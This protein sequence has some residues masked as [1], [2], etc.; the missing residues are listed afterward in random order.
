MC[1]WGELRQPHAFSQGRETAQDNDGTLI[2]ISET[3]L[4][5]YLLT[6]EARFLMAALNTRR[7]A[8]PDTK[9]TA[10][11]DTQSTIAC[12]DPFS[13]PDVMEPER[14]AEIVAE[15]SVECL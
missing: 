15:A 6:I 14:H 9:E 1:T 4:N 8:S 12:F 13:T 3:L 11:T 7:G 5:A 10:V 2:H